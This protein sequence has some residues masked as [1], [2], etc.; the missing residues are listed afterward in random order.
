[1]EILYYKVVYPC[2]DGTEYEVIYYD[3]PGIRSGNYY[4][5]F[6]YYSNGS[7]VII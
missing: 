4:T 5:V 7:C 1:M 3:D 2:E 6:I